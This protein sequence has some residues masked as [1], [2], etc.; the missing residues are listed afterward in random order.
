MIRNFKEQDIISCIDIINNVW[1]FDSRFVPQE[2]SDL[3]KN[4]YVKGSLSNSNFAIVDVYDSIVN[5][6]LFGRCGRKSCF[7]TEYS[8]LFG[9][10]RFIEQLFRIR[11]VKIFRKLHFLRIALAHEIN[12]RQV[13]VGKTNEVCL[14]AVG[15]SS[16]GKGVGKQLMISFIDYCKNQNL[17]AITLE[18]D[19]SSN[20]GFYEHFGFQLKGEFNSLLQMEYSGKSDKTLVYELRI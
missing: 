15:T 12:R 16:Q 6:F 9:G 13:P 8:G 14:F 18:T 2:L 7:H 10:L 5:G 20:Y 1:E 17:S 11:S 19:L 3:L 4:Y